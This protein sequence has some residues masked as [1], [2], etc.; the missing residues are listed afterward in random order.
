EVTGL[1][2]TAHLHGAPVEDVLSLIELKNPWPITGAAEGDI[3]LTLATGDTTASGTVSIPDAVVYITTSN[4]VYPLALDRISGTFDYAQ[5]MVRIHQAQIDR[6]GTQVLVDGSVG[7]NA[8]GDPVRADLNFRSGQQAFLQDLPLDLFGVPVD[9]H[10]PVTLQGALTGVLAGDGP[11]PPA[12]SVRAASPQLAVEGLPAGTSNIALTYQFG[13]DQRELTIASGQVENA[14]FR[15]TS[16]GVYHLSQGTTD[17]VAFDVEHI[18]LT[19]LHNLAI[20]APTDG[21]FS[22]IVGAIAALPELAG[23][24]E[25]HIAGT[26]HDTVLEATL[27]FAKL[28]L[29]GT[30]LPDIHG[31]LSLPTSGN[32]RGIRIDELVASGGDGQGTARL[33]GSVGRASGLDLALSMQGITAKVLSPWIGHLPF[34]G[35]TSLAAT[36]RGPWDAPVLDADLSVAQPT[37]YAH[38]LDKLAGH[39][40]LGRDGLQFTDGR[41]WLTPGSDPATVAGQMPI[42]WTDGFPQLQDNGALSL[43]VHLPQQ[44]LDAVRSLLPDGSALQGTVEAGLQ[45]GGTLAHPY[46]SHGNIALAGSAALPFTDGKLPNQVHDLNLRATLT[47]NGKQSQLTIAQGTATL[48]RLVD[49]KRPKAFQPGWV[50]TSGSVTIPAADLRDPNRWQWD[51]YAQITRLPLA[52]PLSLVPQVSGYLHLGEDSGQPLLTGVMLVDHT[53]VY[54]P[55]LLG[56]T[57]M[58][59][60]PFA[61][62]PHFSIV[63][64]VG[65][66]V[67]L[68]KSII[69]LPLRP[70]P[71]PVPPVSTATQPGAIQQNLPAFNDSAAMLSPDTSGEASGTWGVLTGSLNDPRLYMRFEVAKEKLTFPL[72]LIGSVRHARGHVT[73]SFTDGVHLAMGIPDFPEA[74]AAQAKAS[75]K[76]V[77]AAATLKAGAKL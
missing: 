6:Q 18:D 73:F 28:A 69:R 16:H 33:S 27:A 66:Q 11:E 72:S 32:N 51:V 76:P 42:T 62:N 68:A 57:K 23:S 49:G 46:L 38:T 5:G 36:V 64:Q 31:K 12:V 2:A 19:A 1:A 77:Q 43:A 61:F 37:L 63:L 75:A 40:H 39:L 45:V 9:L 52:P 13:Q 34:D 25:V 44:S 55:T 60:G 4:G 29:H 14:A 53:K 58:S 21:R 47:G 67:K 59:W 35:N 3:H 54:I 7:H 22:P 26:Q 30:P 41:L 48:D 71:L 8:S 17:N 10:G 24:G 74:Q 20:S 70:T 15:A 50:S 65:E 56:S